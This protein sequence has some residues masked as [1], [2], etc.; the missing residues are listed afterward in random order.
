MV[1]AYYRNLY[2]KHAIASIAKTRNISRTCS[3]LLDIAAI[4]FCIYLLNALAWVI[5]LTE[6]CHEPLTRTLIAEILGQNAFIS[7]LL[8]IIPLFWPFYAYFIFGLFIYICSRIEYNSNKSFLAANNLS[9][10]IVAFI[11]PLCLSLFVFLYMFLNLSDYL[12]EGFIFCGVFNLL[13]VLL[14]YMLYNERRPILLNIS[15][16][17][18]VLLNAAAYVYALVWIFNAFFAD[19][20]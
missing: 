6:I 11:S 17:I 1:M 3:I 16:A 14:Q 13:G 4:F 20:L 9:P 18:M 12:L 7:F 19:Y 10:F 2:N 5:F 15:A 8:P